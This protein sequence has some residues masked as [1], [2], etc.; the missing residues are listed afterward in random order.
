MPLPCPRLFVTL[1]LLCLPACLIADPT[2]TRPAEGKLLKEVWEAAYLEGAHVGHIHRAYR[3]VKYGERTIIESSL[4]MDLRLNRNGQPVAVQSIQATHENPAGKLRGFILQEG[5]KDQ[6]LFRKGRVAGAELVWTTQVG[7]KTPTERRLPWKD[8]TLGLYAQ[9]QALAQHLKSGVASFT[10][11]R[12]EPVFDTI[13]SVSVVIGDSEETTL[14]GTIRRKLRKAT[15]QLDPKLS[16]DAPL[17]FLW[18]DDVGEVWKRQTRLPL[19]GELVS[20]R[21]TQ[22]LATK[23]TAGS[24]LDIGRAQLV[25]VAK[26]LLKPQAAKS[27]TYVATLREVEDAASAFPN[28]EHQTTR[29][30]NDGRLEIKITGLRQP[31]LVAT[32]TG[33]AAPRVATEYL[34][35]NFFIT[36]DDPQ[37]QRLA[38]SAV[39]AELDPWSKAVR[40][41][42]WVRQNMR[43]FST[44]EGFATAADVA[45][46]LSGDCK[47]H[48]ILAAA[49]CRA[50]AVPSRIVVGLIYIPRERAFGFHMWLEVWVDGHWY[51]L[52]PTV[53]QGRVA[54]DH[55][56]VLDH[57]LAGEQSFAPM[58]PLARILGKVKLD[59]TDVDYQLT[60]V[61]R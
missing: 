33:L 34:Q 7:S 55:I 11:E 29:L 42:S 53:G 18:I 45:R 58:L 28:D 32:P 20:Y 21:A 16:Q 26:A 40:I 38:R 39:G 30:L 4:E 48:A 9:E 51:A 12:F 2:P 50:Q 14:A 57:S 23:H 22:E 19:L 25:P 8:T 47:G 46:T 60:G 5:V 17:E 10:Y 15:C 35:S 44:T 6:R 31:P 13:L 37:V 27:A 49:M 1:L 24:T 36:S 52:D 56:K 54:A 59:L 3:E 41:E 61:L 43:G